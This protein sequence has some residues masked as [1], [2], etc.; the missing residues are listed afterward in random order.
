MARRTIGWALLPALTLIGCTA[1]DFTKQQAPAAGPDGRAY[2]GLVADDLKKSFADPSVYSSFEI[3]EFRWV[4]SLKG[5]NWRV[6]V[7][8]QEQERQRSY[9][10]F[11]K[12]NSIVDSRYA[13]ETDACD[14]ESYSP[15][16]VGI[17]ATYRAAPGGQEP[18][19]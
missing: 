4:H 8:F 10:L 13:V 14:S 3:S 5:W 19:Y 15:L 2:N 11:I 1:I 16:N 9:V 6:C 17:G 18:I 12:D 7:R